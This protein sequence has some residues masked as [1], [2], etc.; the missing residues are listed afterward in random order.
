MGRGRP[1]IHLNFEEVVGVAMESL[2]QNKMRTLL[3]MLGIVIGVG[4]VICTVAIGQGGSQ[5]VQEQ[6]Q[7]MGENIVFVAAGSVNISGV[8]MGSSATKTLTVFDAQAIAQQIPTVA[9]VSPGVGASVQAING[10]QNWYT[11]LGGVSPEYFQIRR[12]PVERGSGFSERDVNVAANVCVLG[13]TV[14]EQ[15]FGNQDPTGQTIRVKSIPFRVLGELSTKGQSTVGQDQ[16]DVILMPYTTVQKKI[17]GIDWLQY[18]MVS[19]TSSGD[20]DAAEDQMRMLLRQR[21]H[22]RPVEDDD[23]I[24]RSTNELV[25]AQEQTSRV[26]TLLLASVASVSLLV[27]GIGIMNI[28]LVSVTE[29]TR[30]IGLRM[31][32]GAT[33]RA[34]ELQF[35][36]EAVVLSMLGG[37]AGVFFGSI[38]SFVVSKLFNWTTHLSSGSILV[39]VLFSAGVGIFFGF[40]PARRAAHLHPVEAL[41]YE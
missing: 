31:A 34:V 2:A 13:R 20:I 21:H 29:R 24:I 38:A 3:T 4:A 22:L 32:I 19:A 33:K 12:W 36:C 17:A 11:R 35:L 1:I 8:R 28:M 39:A 9:R 27:G 14:A 37:L 41:R 23:F 30:E 25:K 18:I 16:D 40:F 7:N 10:N 26:L 5:K 15:L 6:I